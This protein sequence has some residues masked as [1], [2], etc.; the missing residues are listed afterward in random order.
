APHPA[1]FAGT[2]FGPGWPFVRP[3]PAA[4]VAGGALNWPVQGADLTGTS[5]NAGVLLRD[6]PAGHWIAGTEVTLPLGED[7]VRNYQQAGLIAYVSDDHFARL[8]AVAIWNTR[9]GE[10]G[11]EIR[12]AGT[13]AYRETSA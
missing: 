4:N 12:C 7:T 13:S 10:F 9:Q 1:E 11:Y 5:N 8:S 2:A 6:A 3:D